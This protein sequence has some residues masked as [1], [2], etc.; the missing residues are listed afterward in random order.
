METSP[1]GPIY[2]EVSDS[3]RGFKELPDVRQLLVGE[4]ALTNGQIDGQYSNEAGIRQKEI[5]DSLRPVIVPA[6]HDS[7]ECNRFRP[8]PDCK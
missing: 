2:G 8:S 1:D 3:F 6:D 5:P 7:M 4:L